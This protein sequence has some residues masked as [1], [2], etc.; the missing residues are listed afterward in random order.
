MSVAALLASNGQ[1]SV[2][3]ALYAAAEEEAEGAPS[4]NAG[5]SRPTD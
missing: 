5:F 4:F 3:P 2:Q 1:T